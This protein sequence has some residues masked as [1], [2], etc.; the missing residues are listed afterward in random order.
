MV[1][2]VASS[3][4]RI[5]ELQGGLG[6]KEFNTTLIGFVMQQEVQVMVERDATI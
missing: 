4:L 2:G 5:E 1:R 3:I 6:D